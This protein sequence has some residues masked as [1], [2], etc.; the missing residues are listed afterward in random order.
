MSERYG[1]RRVVL[2][3]MMP[4]AAL[5]LLSPASARASPYLLMCVRI[6]VGVGESA[7]VPS[8]H[9]L[10]AR[11]APTSERSRLVG[12]SWSGNYI[13]SGLTFPFVSFLCETFGW[14]SVFYVTSSLGFIWVM[15]WMMFV[16]DSPAQNPRIS[17]LER[18]Y[19]Q[20]HTSFKLGQ[21]QPPVPWRAIM[22]SLPFWCILIAHMCGNY[23]L[24]MHLT[25][26]PTYMKEVLKFDLKA[27]GLYSMLPFLCM[28]LCMAAAGSA[29]D[30]LISKKLLSRLLTRKLMG[31][32]GLFLPAICIVLLASMDCHQQ[33]AA[34]FLLCGAV[35]FSG[36]VYAGFMINHGE[37]APQLAGTLFGITNLAATVPGIVA[38]Y[39][40]S[41]VTP[42]KTQEEWQVAFYVDAAIHVLG[43]VVYLLFAQTSVQK[44]AEPKR[45][46][47]YKVDP[48]EVKSLV[49]NDK[50]LNLVNGDNKV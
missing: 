16:F 38:P 5:G 45:K 39:F 13:G 24:Y 4:V 34:V 30:A 28:W 11:W 1:P 8:M 31:C 49:Q 36:L 10:F 17:C 32:L 44:W 46:V 6:L 43:G 41:A 42:N 25:Q 14:D 40:V 23:G 18:D 22:T 2:W 47:S 35:G 7:F 21:K 33:T 9:A 29:A 37:I 48:P 26:L 27:N 12:I 50:F 20:H 3:T 19:I 15:L